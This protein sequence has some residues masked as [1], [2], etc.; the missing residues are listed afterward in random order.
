MGGGKIKKQRRGNRKKNKFVHQESLKKNN[1]C[2]GFSIGK[3]Y[4]LKLKKFVQGI[5]F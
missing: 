1:S 3:N 2:R 4:K 5:I